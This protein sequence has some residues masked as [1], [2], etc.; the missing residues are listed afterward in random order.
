[1]T[2]EADNPAR[3]LPD[4]TGRHE[5]RYWN[6]SS[7]A[8][9]VANKGVTGQDPLAAAPVAT[10]VPD[11]VAPEE[12]ATST[13]ERTVESSLLPADEPAPTQSPSPSPARKSWYTRKLVWAAAAI[14]V[15]L[16]IAAIAGGGSSDNK[17]QASAPDTP[18]ATKPSAIT[19]SPKATAAPPTTFCETAEIEL[20]HGGINKRLEIPVALAQQVGGV[21]L[22]RHVI[23]VIA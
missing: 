17:K 13:S 23:N 1:M 14:V 15:L 2:N 12:I 4:P 20:G 7:W 22:P 11:G 16:V 5:Y 18:S 10:P 6:G 3:W 19:T 8:D 9:D 21:Q